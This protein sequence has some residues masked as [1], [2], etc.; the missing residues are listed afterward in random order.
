MKDVFANLLTTTSLEVNTGEN[1]IME[2][3]NGINNKIGIDNNVFI[4]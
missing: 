2:S 4:Y 1:I 3:I